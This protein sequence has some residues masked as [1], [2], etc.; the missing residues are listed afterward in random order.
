MDIYGSF[1]TDKKITCNSPAFADINIITTTVGRTPA[2][3]IRAE[4][5][6]FGVA[7]LACWIGLHRFVTR[8]IKTFA[9]NEVI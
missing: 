6:L 1:P 9:W 3:G 8:C 4:V 5:W 7:K 2:R